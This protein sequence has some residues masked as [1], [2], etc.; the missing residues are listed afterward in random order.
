MPGRSCCITTLTCPMSW[1]RASLEPHSNA[2]ILSLTE[3]MSGEVRF[4]EHSGHRVPQDPLLGL[5]RSIKL[6]EHVIDNAMPFSQE[7][8]AAYF[9]MGKTLSRRGSFKE[10]L[11]YFEQALARTQ[12]LDEKVEALREA[13]TSYYR[14]GEYNDAGRM[15]YEGLQLRPSDQDRWMLKVALDQLGA[16]APALPKAMVFPAANTRPGPGVNLSFEDMAPALGVNRFDGNGTCAWGDID[17]DGDY[18]LVLA[19]SGTFLAVYRNEGGKFVEVT[20]EV[21][22]AGVPSGYSLNLVDYDNDGKLDLYVSLN[23]WSGPMKNKLFRNV[24]G[25]FVDVSAASGA[26]DAGDGFVSLWGDLDNDGYLDLVIANG[27][28]KD[29]S[30]PQIY[31]NKGDGTFENVTKAAGLNEPAQYGAIGI[32][33][34]DYGCCSRRIMASFAFLWSTTTMGIQSDA[35]RWGR[36]GRRV[37]GLSRVRRG[38]CGGSRSPTRGFRRSFPRRGY[39]SR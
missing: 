3:W 29:G 33:L 25:R 38:R 12:N 32:A 2:Y 24:G 16:A 11:L 15:F 21:G 36:G 20:A 13:G 14:M 17:G 1:G 26:D 19:G 31:R 39:R 27:V 23:G 28:L 22:L 18:D 8:T 4:T 30:V 5:D 10:S 35:N 9:S 7:E 34:G 6:L 37:G